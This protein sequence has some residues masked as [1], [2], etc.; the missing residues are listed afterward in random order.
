MYEIYYSSV[1]NV[2]CCIFPRYVMIRYYISGII[3]FPVYFSMQSIWFTSVYFEGIVDCNTECY[4]QIYYCCIIETCI[5]YIYPSLI[6]RKLVVMIVNL[7]VKLGHSKIITLLFN[8]NP[9]NL[10]TIFPLFYFK[11]NNAN[12]YSLEIFTGKEVRDCFFY[13]NLNTSR[14]TQP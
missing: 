2:C 3:Y 11:K 9:V 13:R 10:V 6:F 5:R 7:I 12:R 1:Y 14:Y 4:L 8:A